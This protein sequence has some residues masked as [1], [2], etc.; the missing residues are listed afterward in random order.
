MAT[1][2]SN[3]A[4]ASYSFEGSS[5]T[6]TTS[7]NIAN[8]TLLDEYGL[9]IDIDSL[10]DTFNP[11]ENITYSIVLNNTG[12]GTLNN[13]SIVLNDSIQNTYVSGSARLISSG[14]LISITPTPTSPL[15]FTIPDTLSSGESLTLLYL[16]NV[17]NSIDQSITSLTTTANA[18]ASSASTVTQIVSD[19]DSITLNRSLEASLF[20]TKEVSQSTIY[21]NDSFDYILTITNTGLAEA[22][23]VVISDQLPNGFTINNITLNNGGIARTIDPSEY[24]ISTTNLLTL[25]NNSSETI[26]ILP[27]SSVD[28][29]ITGSFN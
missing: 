18:T 8:T 28:L 26:N 20:I 10:Q 19:T 15:T 23:N 25:P 21:P 12:R 29:T 1:L 9:E 2:I 7:S 17:S 11:G 27:S 22:T 5:E 3:Q 6:L 14:N 24:S 16:T 4:S 13:F